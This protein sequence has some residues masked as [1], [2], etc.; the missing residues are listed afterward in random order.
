[1]DV[2]FK[3]LPDAEGKFFP[4]CVYSGPYGGLFELET[5][6]KL[7]RDS[8][9]FTAK[10]AYEN[11]NIESQ[12]EFQDRTKAYEPEK[13]VGLFSKLSTLKNDFRTILEQFED[14]KQN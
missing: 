5:Y 2:D 7:P 11:L 4:E 1:M 8:D 6:A 12:Q 10:V 9:E 14:L 13:V 3:S